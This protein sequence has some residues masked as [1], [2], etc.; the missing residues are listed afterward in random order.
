MKAGEIFFAL[1]DK[2][3][4]ENG[5]GPKQETAKKVPMVNGNVPVIRKHNVYNLQRGE[6]L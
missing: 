2:I 5:T 6:V 1:S 3:L 4:H